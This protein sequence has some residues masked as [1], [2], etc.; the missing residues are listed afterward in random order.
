MKVFATWLMGSFPRALSVTMGFAVL[1]FILPP[2]TLLSNAIP[3]LV[4]LRMG[5]KQ[6]LLMAV[7]LTVSLL[8][9]F[10]LVGIA[11]KVAVIYVLSQW[12]LPVVLAIWLKRNNDWQQV[13]QL[14]LIIA[15]A[16]LILL[17]ATFGD[18]SGYWQ[19]ILNTLFRPALERAQIPAEEIE[20]LLPAVASYM[21]GA[22]VAGIVFSSIIVL[23][24]ARYIQAVV[25]NPGGFEDEFLQLRAGQWPALAVLAGM[26]FTMVSAL[27]LARELILIVMTL[28]F[29]QGVAIIHAL[30]KMK[31]WHP[32]WIVTI[33]AGLLLMTIPVSL[34][35]AGLG[36]IDTFLDLRKRLSRML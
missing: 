3:A 22:M 28:Y 25:Y 31:K 13:L 34:M 18:L 9:F 23:L 1:G 2:L 36:L 14:L 29:F 8:V 24:L 4:T 35:L 30:A 12:F 20:L 5:E 16:T 6:G 11:P 17:H 19:G 27:P 7:I 10:S 33:Y 21:T 15:A 26:L 32:V